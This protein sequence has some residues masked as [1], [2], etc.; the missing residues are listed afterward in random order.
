[1]AGNAARDGR[2]GDLS[3]LTAAAPGATV[4]GAGQLTE[5]GAVEGRLKVSIAD[6][7]PF[8]GLAG[9]P[10]AGALDLEAN[11]ERVGDTGFTAELSGSTKELR[12][13]IAAADALL[14]GA[15]T[16]NGSVERDAA[17]VLSVK[18]LA[19]AGPAISLS[20]EGGFSPASNEL[21]ATLAA[22]LP[23]L[24]PLGAA[25]GTEMAGSVS[26]KLDLAGPLDGLRADGQI[27]GTGL[28]FAGTKLD[29]LRI[30]G[31]VADLAAPNGV[32]D[33]SFRAYGLDGTL[34]L[35]AEMKPGSELV[36]PRLRVAAADSTIDASLRI[37]LDTGLVQGSVSGRAPDLSRLSKLA[38]MPLGGSFELTAGLD[39]KKGQSVELSANGTRL[40]AGGVGIGRLALSAR[41]ADVLRTPSGTARLSLSSVNFG[42]GEFASATVALDLRITWPLYI[43]GRR[44]GQ[45]V[46]RGIGRRCRDRAEPSRSSADPADWLARQ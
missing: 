5:T 11:A 18:R 7:R 21:S 2:S 36:V 28:A 22:E 44:Q 8:S 20:G 39:A 19:V 34:A 33:G 35:A 41:M 15:T 31:R 17:G 25:L 43:P 1:M 23:R 32:V 14:G 37:A 4:S 45:A 27:E 26:A 3:D 30:S 12:T 42:G 6:L 40:A 29:R 9:Y 24:K 38:G 16:I 46:D 13:G 10:L